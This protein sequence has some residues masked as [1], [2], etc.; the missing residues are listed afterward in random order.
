VSRVHAV[1][2]MALACFGLLTVAQC[3]KAQ[4]QQVVSAL[5]PVAACEVNELLGGAIED[6]VLLLTGC[7]ATDATALLNIVEDLLAASSPQGDA[8][9]QS[10]ALT[11]ALP[12]PQ[13]QHLQR[14]AANLQNYIAAHD[15]GRP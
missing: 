8:S 15:A 7:L 12:V 2:G 4:E 3:T 11:F 10:K 14:I 5:G 13:V 9:A 1:M 6:P